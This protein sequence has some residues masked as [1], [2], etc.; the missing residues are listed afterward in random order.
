M[1]ATAQANDVLTIPA[2]SK[3]AGQFTYDDWLNNN[4]EKWHPP[5]FREFYFYNFTN[6][7]PFSHSLTGLIERKKERKELH[8]K[9]L[10]ARAHPS[11][12]HTHTHTRARARNNNADFVSVI[13]GQEKL[14]VE[15]IG[16]IAFKKKWQRFPETVEY[17][18]NNNQG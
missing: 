16:P 13:T 4:N 1:A 10:L 6:T 14:V 9:S 12:T 18:D 7:G 8:A 11:H 17:I 3:T 5:S 15:K 2:K